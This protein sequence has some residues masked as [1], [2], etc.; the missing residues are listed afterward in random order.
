MKMLCM[1]AVVFT[2]LGL[3]LETRAGKSETS[4]GSTA[5]VA[6][7]GPQ[8]WPTGD[9]AQV[10]QEYSVP[11]YVGLPTK[12]YKVLGR[13]YDKRT[14]GLE[15]VGRAFDEGLGSENRR[16]RNCA[17]Q[18]RLQGGDAVLV[19]SNA[20]FVEAFKLTRRELRDTTPLFDYK[21]CVTLAIKF[22]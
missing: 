10:I 6:Y 12:H 15:V 11:I 9:K 7:E 21:D 3:A 16:M 19:T 14:T 13:I 1:A 4:T 8:S 22:D 2:S 18:A 20:K 5:F 17:N